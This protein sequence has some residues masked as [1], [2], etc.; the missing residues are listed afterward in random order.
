MRFFPGFA[1]P[2]RK[3]RRLCGPKGS[4]TCGV[5]AADSAEIT[6]TGRFCS[7]KTA[8]YAENNHVSRPAPIMIRRFYGFKTAYSA[9]KTRSD[10]EIHRIFNI[11]FA[12]A[13]LSSADS[14]DLR[15]QEM[16]L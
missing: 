9:E 3:P 2:L 16:R 14:A 8:K 6:W 1:Q 12:A 7:V 13:L 10:D 11:F 15:G 5:K 4:R